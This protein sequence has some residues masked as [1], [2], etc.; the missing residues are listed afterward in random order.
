MSDRQG[1]PLAISNP[2]AGNH[3]D[4]YNIE[5]QFKI[6]ICTL[7]QANIPVEGLFLNADAGFDSKEF[8]L[9][10][11]KK[12]INANVC[13]NKRNGEADRDEYFDPLLYKQ[14]LKLNEQMHGWTVLGHCLIDLIHL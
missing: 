12:E 8:R 4:L 10:C 11:G 6:V 7:E 3:N 9:C 13:F 5:A 1:L 14:K 2:V